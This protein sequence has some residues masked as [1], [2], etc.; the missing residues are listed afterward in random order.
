MKKILLH[1]ITYSEK[2]T[3]EKVTSYGFVIFTLMAVC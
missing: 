3:D 2:K 1:A